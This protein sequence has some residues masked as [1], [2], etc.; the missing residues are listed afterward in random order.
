MTHRRTDH[1]TLD[2]RLPEIRLGVRKML[3]RMLAHTI[4]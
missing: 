4:F 3:A 1:G 2:T